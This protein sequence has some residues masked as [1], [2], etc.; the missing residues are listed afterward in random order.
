MDPQHVLKMLQETSR[1]PKLRIRE[2][3]IYFVYRE[4]IQDAAFVYS[5]DIE[6]VSF[7]KHVLEGLTKPIKETGFQAAHISTTGRYF[8]K[9]SYL[10]E[11]TDR[12]A[13]PPQIE[14]HDVRVD[15]ILKITD[16][17]PTIDATYNRAS[18]SE[19]AI[20]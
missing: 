19:L 5:E 11:W 7:P 8:R 14:S 18:G 13:D 20:L 16:G 10:N 1:N 4:D 12:D 9:K 2:N 15:I 3:K 17:E 6:E